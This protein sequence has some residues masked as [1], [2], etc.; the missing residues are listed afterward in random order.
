MRTKKTKV[1]A[2]QDIVNEYIEAGQPWP[3]DRK[4]IAAWA[5]NSKKWAPQRRSM[6]DQCAQ[7]LADAMRQE[8]EKDP[9]G[10][11]VRAKLCAKISEKDAEGNLVQK[12]IWFGRD[13]E[14]KL[15]HLGLQQQRDSILGDCKSL[16]TNQDSYNDN[17]SYGA[18]IQLSFDFT[19]D[20]EDSEHD[21]EYNPPSPP[22]DDD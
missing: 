10:R 9:Q 12:T 16:K 18:T 22:G 6:I 17:N 1:E 5:V 8:L 15:M 11:T 4:T 20:I 2:N 13:A 14:P 21:T 7:E 19:K 3:A